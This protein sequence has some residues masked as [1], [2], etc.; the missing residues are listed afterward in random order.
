MNLIVGSA[1]TGSLI[2]AKKRRDFHFKVFL[3]QD[4][5][6]EA[7]VSSV[8]LSSRCVFTSVPMPKQKMR[9][10]PAFDPLHVARGSVFIGLTNGRAAVGEEDDDEGTICSSGWVNP[11]LSS[12]RHQSLCRQWASGL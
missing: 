2:L 5:L 6:A 9:V 8:I 11:M 4:V 1:R 7:R 10:R 3:G 12:A